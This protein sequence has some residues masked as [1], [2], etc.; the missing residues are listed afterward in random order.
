MRFKDD[1]AHKVRNLAEGSRRPLYAITLMSHFWFKSAS[2]S[3]IYSV[4][5]ASSPSAF[6][7]LQSFHRSRIRRVN[8]PGQALIGAVPA[9]EHF[10]LVIPFALSWILAGRIHL[11]KRIR[12]SPLLKAEEA[13]A[14]CPRPL[15][16]FL[17]WHYVLC[18]WP[19]P[20]IAFPRHN[21]QSH[22]A[23]SQESDVPTFLRRVGLLKIGLSGLVRGLC[24][25]SLSER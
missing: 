19:Q 21:F 4:F 6:T 12:D 3:V 18:G 7:D 11:P 24:W 20:P 8:L 25:D 17:F 23:V 14:L 2:N 22:I 13:A 5:R 1:T 9:I 10:H 16:E 15:E